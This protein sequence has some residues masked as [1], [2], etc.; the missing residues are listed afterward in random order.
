MRDYANVG[1]ERDGPVATIVFERDDKLNSFTNEMLVDMTEILEELAA[2]GETRVCVMRGEGRAFSTGADLSELVDLTPFEVTASNRRWIDFF[3]LVETVPF[4][5]VAQ[6]HGWAIAGGTELTL[7][8][9][10]VVASDDAMFGLTEIRVGVIPGAGASVRLSRW[11]G[12]A[13]AKEILMTGD[14]FSAG[15][16]FRLGLVNRVVPRDRLEDEVAGLAAKLASRGPLAVAAAKR[17]VNIGSELDLEKG[18]E[19][20]LREFALLFGSDDKREGMSAFLEKREPRF[21]GGRGGVEIVVPKM[22][23]TETHATVTR[24][25]V[26]AGDRVSAGQ[27]VAE[28]EADKADVEVEAP[29]D[30]VVAELL[31]PEGT[32]VELGAPIAVLTGAGAA[33]APAVEPAPAKAATGRRPASPL[34]RRVAAELGVDVHALAG[35]G[36]G[37][38]V[39]ERDV[40]AAAVERPAT[41]AAPPAGA[42]A[43]AGVGP[44]REVELSRLRRVTAQRLVEAAA[45]PTVTLHR[46]VAIEGG[47]MAVVAARIHGVRATLTHAFVAACALALP[48]FPEL[49]GFWIDGRLWTSERINVGIAV[50]VPDGLRVAVVEDCG[51]KSLV[52]L[53]RAASEAVE[54]TRA[55]K[56]G[57]AHATF[58]I[59]N[60]GMLGVE[61]FTPLLNPPQTGILGI[62]A[63]TPEG[64]ALSLTFD[65]RAIDGAPAARFLDAVAR[66]LAGP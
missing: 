18:I 11:V 63:S 53:A 7:A 39:V 34:A 3:H 28:V 38:L 17:A 41:P 44:L 6:V 30:G 47:R 56:S 65:H 13:Q 46:R 37:G 19:Y 61:S 62:G 2:D 45:V 14:P 59:S 25:L 42:P 16:A 35:T 57:G 23:L 5:V 64:L 60:M 21:T 24:W 12:R 54:A 20:V 31:V 27:A 48:R 52:E 8:C 29:G 55:G 26:A 32:R 33:A 4:P 1:V 10:L 50:D 36:P 15:E 51:G 58:T 66:E 43:L 9:D 40:R 22:G 49:N